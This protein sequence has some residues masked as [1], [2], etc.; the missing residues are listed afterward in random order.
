MKRLART[1]RDSGEDVRS[2]KKALF[3]LVCNECIFHFIREISGTTA[4][5]IVSLSSPRSEL[6]AYGPSSKVKLSPVPVGAD[7]K[8]SLYQKDKLHKFG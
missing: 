2:N 7:K 6:N 5:M 1:D 4:K 8:A 3:D